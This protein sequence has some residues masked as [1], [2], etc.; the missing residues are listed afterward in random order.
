M[1]KLLTTNVTLT[2]E[3]V[4]SEHE[5]PPTRQSFVSPLVLYSNNEETHSSPSSPSREEVSVHS[6][7]LATDEDGSLSTDVIELLG[8]RLT[9]NRKLAPALHS[10]VTQRWEKMYNWDSAKERKNLIDE[11]PIPKNCL[12]LDPPTLNDEM[13]LMSESARTGTGQ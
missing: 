3:Y 2:D 9:D 8:C 7:S 13:C 11:Y 1:D 12:F 4:Y 10:D 6:Q 5:S